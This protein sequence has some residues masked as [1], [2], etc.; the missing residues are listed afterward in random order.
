VRP[1]DPQP[2]ILEGE[3][4][5]LEPLGDRHAVDLFEASR[6]P[7]I[8]TYLLAPQPKTVADIAAFIRSSRT[9][10]ESG[11]RIAFAVWDKA[12]SRAVGVTCYYEIDRANRWLEI[13]GTWYS[14]QAQGTA[15]NTE[16]KLLLLR[17]AFTELGAVRVQLKTD[18]LNE[19]SRR[20]IE[21]IGARFE[22]LLRNYQ[23]YW[24][25]RVR[26]SALYS[27]L[28]S[29][30]PEVKAGLEAMLQAPRTQ[31]ATS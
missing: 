7:S 23:T 20:A 15:V 8:W 26:D 14:A 2:L 11:E 27:I 4:V 6:D 30:W 16:C 13:G 24:H 31:L 19:R 28:D 17:H 5:R 29:E 18:A 21:R 10:A 22:G 12:A 9:R 3:R 1:F 25:G